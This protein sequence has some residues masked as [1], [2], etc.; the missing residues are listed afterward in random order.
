MSIA[1]RILSTFQPFRVCMWHTGRCGSSVVADLIERD[2]RIDWAG[3]ILERPSKDW[4][5]LNGADALR[6]CRKAINWRRYEAGRKPFGFEMKL[7]HHHRLD[8]TTRDMADL[9]A[10][11]GFGRHVILERK[12]TLRQRVSGRVAEESGRYHRRTGE[13]PASVSVTIDLATL[14]HFMELCEAYY[15]SLRNIHPHAVYLT[16]EG[17]IEA[18]P[19]AAYAKIMRYVGLEPQGV[20]TDRQ[21][22][23]DRPLPDVI[24]NYGEVAEALSGTAHEWMLG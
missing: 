11:L 4:S 14:A 22:T 16:Y 18:D 19:T 10:D 9:M 8:L 1:R 20:T 7:W 21:K 12:N 15:R 17:D 23:T 2:G 6:R 24:V 5:G 13:E 3:E